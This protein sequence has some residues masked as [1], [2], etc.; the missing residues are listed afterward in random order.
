MKR[1]RETATEISRCEINA[2]TVS[3]ANANNKY[4]ERTTTGNAMRHTIVMC[5]DVVF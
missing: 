4:L 1:S 2:K 5:V 3:N